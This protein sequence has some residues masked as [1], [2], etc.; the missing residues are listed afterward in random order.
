MD[1]KPKEA[2]CCPVAA[3]FGMGVAPATSASGSSIRRRPSATATTGSCFSAGWTTRRRTGASA[4]KTAPPP[5]VARRCR[6]GFNR[7][8]H[9]GRGLVLVGDVGG[10]VNLFN[11]EGIAYAIESGELAAIAAH[12]GSAWPRSGHG[13]CRA[14]TG[15]L[16]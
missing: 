14:R 13:Q 16:P 1:G 4:R 6:M 10:M 9:Y 15:V 8:P 5:F 3:G 7:Q 11:G 2:R 12:R